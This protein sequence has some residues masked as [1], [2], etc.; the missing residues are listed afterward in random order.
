MNTIYWLTYPILALVF[1]WYLL[2]FRLVWLSTFE[3]K[4]VD[5]VDFIAWGWVGLLAGGRLGYFIFYN[6]ETLFSDPTLLWDI[7][8]GG[9]S[10]HGAILGFFTAS[11]VVAKI[12]GRSPWPF[13]A[14]STIVAPI[15]IFVGRI[16]NFLNG[17]L[18]GRVTDVPW[19][20]AFPKSGTLENRHPSQLYEAVAEGLILFFLMSF[21]SKRLHA[22][23]LGTGNGSK[24]MALVFVALYS[25]LR[26]A[27]E[28]F[29][30][31]DVQIGYLVFKFTLGQWL[32]VVLFCLVAPLLYH[33][34]QKTNSFVK[35]AP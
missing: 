28:F 26:F 32:S 24:I 8:W 35:S 11:L 29:R 27:V 10:F 12:K 20:M 5:V 4:A 34:W 6:R 33:A 17:E 2:K 9:M 14:E 16:G 18:W 19:G 21:L 3:Y 22:S 23:E 1:S 13:L 31:P 15:A 7:W 30:A 25:V